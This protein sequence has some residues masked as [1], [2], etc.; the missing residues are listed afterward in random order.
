[1]IMTVQNQM[2]EEFIQCLTPDGIINALSTIFTIV[3]AFLVAFFTSR[4]QYGLFKKERSEASRKIFLNNKAYFKMIENSSRMLLKGKNTR[5]TDIQ[6]FLR[7]LNYNL[8]KVSKSG[9]LDYTPS[10]IDPDINLFISSGDM[11]YN[12]FE[13]V[14]SILNEEN[15][16]RYEE[17]LLNEEAESYEYVSNLI[18]SAEKYYDDLKDSMESIIT[19]YK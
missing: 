9:I 10:D 15:I 6:L 1:M 19:Y 14:T 17:F 12:S 16:E 13:I 18:E 4:K 5:A 2:C 11:I 8:K 7:S 3:G